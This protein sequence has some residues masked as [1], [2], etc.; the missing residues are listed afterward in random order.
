MLKKPLQERYARSLLQYTSEPA[1][2]LNNKPEKPGSFSFVLL[3]LLLMSS[4]MLFAQSGN[5]LDFDGSN[6]DVSLGTSLGTFGTGDFSLEVWFK[7]SSS[8]NGTLI[9]KRPVC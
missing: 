4:N 6:D 3:F 7:T 1:L 5:A 2:L 9:S 8:G